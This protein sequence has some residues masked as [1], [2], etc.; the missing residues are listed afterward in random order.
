MVHCFIEECSNGNIFTHWKNNFYTLVINII[1]V[2]H[3]SLKFVSNT[4]HIFTNC[5]IQFFYSLIIVVEKEIFNFSCQYLRKHSRES[6]KGLRKF[7][8]KHFWGRVWKLV[9]Q[10]AAGILYRYPSNSFFQFYSLS[11]NYS[12]KKMFDLLKNI[13]FWKTLKSHCG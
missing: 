8:V 5:Y 2:V 11:G 13:S 12:G 10:M 9:K 3:F 1:T 4:I 6:R 7:D